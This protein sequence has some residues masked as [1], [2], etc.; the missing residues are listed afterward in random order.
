[1]DFKNMGTNAAK[2]DSASRA[3][4]TGRV[5]QDDTDDLCYKC[6]N[7]DQSLDYAFKEVIKA[8]EYN[9][10]LAGAEMVNM[11]LTLGMK[12]G[13][14][15]LATVKP[16][17]ENRKTSNPELSYRVKQLRET[18]ANHKSAKYVPI[19]NR[20]HEADDSLRTMQL[21]RIEKFGPDSSVIRSGDKDLWF[22]EGLHMDNQGR[23]YSGDGYGEVGYRE[24]GNVKPKLI[25]RGTSW[26]WHQLLMGD[27]ADNIPGLPQISGRLANQYLPTKT[28]NPKRKALPCGEAKAVAILKDVT[29]DAE[30]CTRVYRAYDEHYGILLAEEMFVEQ[31]FLL[32]I[33]RTSDLNDVLYFLHDCG[34]FVA[35][36]SKQKERLNA[37]VAKAKEIKDAR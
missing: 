34:S 7:L 21:A 35:F 17:Q 12:G 15:E 27:T 5:L 14:S 20:V 16:Y 13:R 2:S 4:V 32:W 26:F 19:V 8:V 6:A 10:R 18:L 23:F 36:T 1:M 22:S 28:H 31:A 9:R 11:H 3:V 29:N 24:V 30:A 25:G 37:F 33:R